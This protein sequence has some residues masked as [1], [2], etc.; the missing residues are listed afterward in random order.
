ME[1]A[2]VCTQ[3]VPSQLVWAC[4]WLHDSPVWKSNGPSR[5]YGGNNKEVLV[6]KKK[7]KE[8]LVRRKCLVL[9]LIL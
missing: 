4:V 1:L 6:E 5:F 2:A 9:R 3:A 7:K 8:V